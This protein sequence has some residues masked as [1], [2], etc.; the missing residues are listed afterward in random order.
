MDTHLKPL[1]MAWDLG[2]GQMAMVDVK[3]HV[4]PIVD[5]R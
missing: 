3:G 4:S 2:L 1:D 5:S